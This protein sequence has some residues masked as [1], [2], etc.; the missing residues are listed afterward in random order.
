MRFKLLFLLLV[1][2]IGFQSCVSRKQLTYLQESETVNDSIPTIQPVV[3]PYRV[4]VNDILSITLKADDP[5]LVAIFNQSD[6]QQNNTNAF[7]E[8]QLYFNG[9]IV[10]VHGNIR[11]PYLNDIN[12]LGY[13]VEEIRKK[14]ESL[15]L[16]KYLTEST[17]LFVSVKLAGLYFTVT[18]EVGSPGSQVMYR[19]KVNVIEALANAGD[20]AITG[21]RENVVIVRQYPD[22]KKIHHIDITQRSAMESQ[23][24]YVRPNDMIIVN[25]LPQKSLGTGTNGLQTFTTIFS[26]FSVITSTILLIRTL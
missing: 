26:V 13:T 3:K 10:D 17:H 9:Y 5:E 19:D 8:Q 25:P 23:F 1:I 11:I 21:D 15:I 4:Q 14:V 6:T 24:F 12:V 18:G 2:G 16:D 20:V 22:G 7:G